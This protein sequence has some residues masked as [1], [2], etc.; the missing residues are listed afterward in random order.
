MLFVIA[1]VFVFLQIVPE[2]KHNQTEHPEV[3]R[4]LRVDVVA[5]VARSAIAHVLLQEVQADYS[6]DGDVV[7]EEHHEVE[8]K[9]DT[10]ITIKV[11]IISH[12]T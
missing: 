11:K 1:I 7:E 8:T 4:H 2:K 6:D 5:D 12:Q 10:M 9:L 3:A